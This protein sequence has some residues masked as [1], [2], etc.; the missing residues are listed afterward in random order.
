MADVPDYVIR[1]MK[2]EEIPA[3]L[4]LWRETCLSEGT[5]SLDTWFEYDPE[6][7]YVAATEDG[8]VLGSCAGIL[9]NDKLAFVGLYAV[10]STYQRR[11]IGMKIWNAV[12]ERIGDRNVG[13]NPVPD[14]LSNY[15]DK[16]GFPVQTSWCSVVCKIPEIQPENLL[17]EISGVE[18]QILHSNDQQTID[19]VTDYEAD[20]FGFSRGRLTQ[21]LSAQKESLTMVALKDSGTEVCGFGNVK[22]NIKGNALVGPLYADDAEVAELILHHLIK[23]FPTAKDKGVT[24]MTVDSNQ[25]ALELVDSLGFEK[26]HGIARLYRKDEVE[27]KFEKIFGQHNLNFAIF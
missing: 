20:I 6:G 11:G 27:V 19:L 3:V 2:R 9:Q 16:A 8:V 1:P 12:M 21:L 5:Y 14:Q 7:F 24:L 23:E 26:E 13:V 10:R 25:S 18:V 22:K 17:F 15:R 4:D